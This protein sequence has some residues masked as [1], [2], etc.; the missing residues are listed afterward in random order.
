MVDPRDC[1]SNG[2]RGG[3][4]LAVAAIRTQ[5]NGTASPNDVFLKRAYPKAQRFSSRIPLARGHIHELSL[6]PNAMHNNGN[7]V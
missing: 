3:K 4:I 7:F 6:G 5:V 1:C 2:C